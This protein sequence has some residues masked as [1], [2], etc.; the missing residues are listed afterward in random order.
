MTGSVT[1]TLTS[2][3]KGEKRPPGT[4]AA[5]PRPPRQ[6]SAMRRPASS[7]PGTAMPA[8]I[9]RQPSG[10]AETERRSSVASATSASTRG[11]LAGEAD[12]A[13]Q[14]G[15]FGDEGLRLGHGRTS[16]ARRAPTTPRG[17]RRAGGGREWSP[18]CGSGVQGSRQLEHHRKVDE[19]RGRGLAHALQQGVLDRVF[20]VADGERADADAVRQGRRRVM[21]A[22][23]GDASGGRRSRPPPR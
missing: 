9:M 2:V 13:G 16:C 15:G 11:D 6:I 23:A 17:R 3:S 21:G 4:S 5:R 12:P 1:V 14:R 19:E 18:S 22:D 7:E 20:E 8:S 10:P